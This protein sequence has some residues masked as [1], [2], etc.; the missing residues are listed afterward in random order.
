M[1]PSAAVSCPLATPIGPADV[2]IAAPQPQW[3]IP[4][5]VYS[6][7][8]ASATG[9]WAECANG[10]GT[11]LCFCGARHHVI[12]GTCARGGDTTPVCSSTRGRAISPGRAQHGCPTHPAC[13]AR[14]GH[15][16][17]ASMAGGEWAASPKP[18]RAL[19]QA[20]I[21]ATGHH[22]VVE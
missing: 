16:A 10:G 21:A 3:T 19:A 9:L 18:Q 22:Q 6:L 4:R 15:I 20:D 5:R 7:P 13:T 12:R 11:S 2:V 17:H 8:A 1:S 14:F